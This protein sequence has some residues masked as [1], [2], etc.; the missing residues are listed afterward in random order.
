MMNVCLFYD[1]QR[2]KVP[3]L[4]LH[5]Q[6]QTIGQ[7]Q[8]TTSKSMEIQQLAQ[9]LDLSSTGLSSTGHRKR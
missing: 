1:G 8:V 6:F 2:P 3:M 7:L 4:Q 5:S 9:I